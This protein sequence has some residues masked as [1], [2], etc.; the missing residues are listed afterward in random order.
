[1]KAKEHKKLYRYTALCSGAVSFLVTAL[2]AI[3]IFSSHDEDMPFGVEFFLV[4]EIF[5]IVSFLAFLFFLPLFA[6]MSSFF[7]GAAK[8]LRGDP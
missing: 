1:M 8:K 4:V 3:I 7:E 6:V 5:C 2:F